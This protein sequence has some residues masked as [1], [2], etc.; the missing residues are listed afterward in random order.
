MPRLRYLTLRTGFEAGG[1]CSIKRT[2]STRFREGHDEIRD[3]LL[4]SV[5]FGECTRE[6]CL[7][8]CQSRSRYSSGD[9][10][11]FLI[12]ARRSACLRAG[13]REREHIGRVSNRSA[14]TMDWQ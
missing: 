11:Q 8:E 9:E 14:L 5:V 1:Q 13:G 3:L 4:T 10:P 2:I 7:R 12:L 6:K